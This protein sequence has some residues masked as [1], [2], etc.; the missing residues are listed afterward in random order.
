MD[1]RARRESVEGAF[2]LVTPQIVEGESVLLID[3][4]LTTGSTIAACAAALRIA[5]AR[6]VLALTLA[7]PLA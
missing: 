7:R 3:D 6:E 1:A 4:V 5:G 2:A